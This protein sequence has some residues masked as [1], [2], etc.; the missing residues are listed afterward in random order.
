MT[1]SIENKLYE[2]EFALDSRFDLAPV[3]V[4]MQY[5]ILSTPRSGST[6]LCSAL[7]NSTVAG[8]PFE[9]FHY[10]LLPKLGNPEKHTE[11]IMP[12]FKSLQSS[13]TTPNGVFGMK[14]HYSQ[15]ERLFGHNDLGIEFLLNFDRFILTYRRDKVL[16]AISMMLAIESNIWSRN[17]V[18]ESEK[19][20]R[21]FKPSDADTITKLVNDM[22]MQELSWRNIANKIGVTPL[23]IAYEDLCNNSK[24]E[25][26]KV[27]RHLGI[28]T[29]LKSVTAKTTNNTLTATMK[30]AY[31]DYM[32]HGDT[33]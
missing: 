20:G 3:V 27:T 1:N 5:V 24:L 15:Y 9:Y 32:E 17:Y 16:Q 14:F 10:S 6:L 18:A 30:A 2:S 28:H 31:L 8:V 33:L 29:D 23:E 19:L 13:R 4:S 7:H 12:Y 21:A 25:F 26:N 11:L 22:N